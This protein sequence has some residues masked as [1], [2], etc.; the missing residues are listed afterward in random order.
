MEVVLTAT[1]T[2]TQKDDPLPHGARPNIARFS[3]MTSAVSASKKC[4]ADE[5]QRSDKA[6]SDTGV[7]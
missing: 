6:D 1:T 7:A 2:T 5:G 4:E 3:R